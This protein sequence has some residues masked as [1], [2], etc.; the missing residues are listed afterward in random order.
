MPAW[1]RITSG[2]RSLIPT[3]LQVRDTHSPFTEHSSNDT[4]TT[5]LC[6]LPLNY[7][8]QRHGCGCVISECSEHG[9]NCSLHS[10][11]SYTWREKQDINYTNRQKSFL[12]RNQSSCQVYVPGGCGM[13]LKTWANSSLL[14]GYIVP[15]VTVVTSNLCSLSVEE[16]RVMVDVVYNDHPPLLITWYSFDYF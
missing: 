1:L 4:A 6:L 10:G 7:A 12:I 15:L 14:P 9:N 3:S 11:N 13:R 8:Y 16:P 5:G 2:M